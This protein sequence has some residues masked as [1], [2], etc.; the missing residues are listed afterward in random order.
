M[1][2]NN[3]TYEELRKLL[4]T[5]INEEK[6]LEL[7]DKA[8]NFSCEKWSGEKRLTGDDYITHLVNV[9]HI[10]AEIKADSETICGAL[11]HDVLKDNKTT[12]EELKSEFGNEVTSL[13]EGVTK[14]NKLSFN[15]DNEAV[16]A[17]HRKIIVGLSEDV[18]VII[19]KLADR[20]HNM[21]TLWVH[22]EVTQK[23]KAKETLDIL[24]PIAHRLGMNKIKS[25]LDDL[26]LRYYKPDVYFSIVE[27]LNQSKSE[28]DG[29]VVDMQNEVS[30]ILNEHGIKHEIK[31]RAKSIY[32]I[33]KKLDKGKKF[34]DIYDLY[35]LRVYVDTEQDCY[36]VLGI[37]HSKYKPIPKRFKDYVA[38]PKANMYQS[39]HTTVFGIDGHPFEIQ[40]RTY[41]MDRVAELG[42]ASH[43]SYKEKGSNVKASIQ[44]TMEQKLQ[45]FRTIMDLKNEAND[46]EFLKTV[47][48]EV[49]KDNIY[50]FT[51]KGDVV[52]LPV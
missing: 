31:G 2:S 5:Y 17:N 10:L 37:I 23:E 35:A 45:F 11:L 22:P 20:L 51:P 26:S 27:K 36:Q 14:I 13:V 43:W 30:N 12:V 18:R 21:R 3:V 40:I 50:V 15:G 1:S 16:L 8:Y 39:L 25:E 32:S 34:S 9:A 46:E 38:M 49:L 28:R 47:N 48:E 42:I 44:S 29:I 24:V 41:E 6:K 7:I 4:S 19:I 33:Y 52:E